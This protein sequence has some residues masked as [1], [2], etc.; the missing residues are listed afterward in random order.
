MASRVDTVIGFDFGTVWTGVAIGLTLTAQARPLKVIKSINRKPDWQAIGS[1]LAEWQ[2]QRLIVGLPTSMI[3]D[4]HPMTEKVQKFCRQ[5][6]GRFNIPVE[7][8]DERLTTREAYVIAIE[9]N[10][11]KTKQE[12]DSISAM[13]IAESWL[14]HYA[15][16]TSQS[17][18]DPAI[19]PQQLPCAVTE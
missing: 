14:R 10:R 3:H 15:A 18:A 4:H 7:L 19:C 6:E 12:I 5:L 16:T 2:P 8:I 1:L 11:L 13:L 9:N 17:I